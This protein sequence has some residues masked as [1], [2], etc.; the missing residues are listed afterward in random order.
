MVHLNR[1]HT[2]DTGEQWTVW[3]FVSLEIGFAL[4]TLPT[5][6]ILELRN[7]MVTDITDLKMICISRLQL[8]FSFSTRKT[9]AEKCFYFW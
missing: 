1:S 5:C 2:S 4:V 7:Y 3:L 9:T 8:R 6:A